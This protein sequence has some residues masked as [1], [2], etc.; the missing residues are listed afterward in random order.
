MDYPNMSYCMCQ[1][2]LAALDQILTAMDD[3]GNLRFLQDL[4]RDERRAFEELARVC[5]QF[6]NRAERAVDQEED[7]KELAE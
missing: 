3:E 2:T 5:E 1:N 6:V 4:N 7:E